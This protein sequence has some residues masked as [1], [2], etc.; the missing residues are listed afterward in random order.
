MSTGYLLHTQALAQSTAYNSVILSPSKMPYQSLDHLP[1]SL[2]FPLTMKE[3][4]FLRD[5]IT[6]PLTLHYTSQVCLITDTYFFFNSDIKER[7]SHTGTA[8]CFF[9][10]TFISHG[11]T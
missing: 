7:I 5:Y 6:L 8:S 3:R 1:R 2:L 4:S 9:I 11:S 10:Q